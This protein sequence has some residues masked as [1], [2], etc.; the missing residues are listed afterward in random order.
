MQDNKKEKTFQIR[1]STVDFL[2]FT[3]QNSEDGIEVRVQ[4]ESLWLTQEG[5]SQLF[6]KGRTTITEHLKNIF[7]EGE[8]E[9]SSVCRKFRHTGSD[10]KNYNTKF[11]SLDAIISVGYRVNSVRA[12]QFRQWATKVLRTYTIQGYVLDKKRLENGQ[13]FDEE[14]FEHL[15]DEIRE[16]RASE[17]KFYQKITDIYATAVDY[18]KDAY[19][20]KDFFAT[21]QN[22][23]SDFRYIPILSHCKP[24][25]Q[26]ILI[27]PGITLPINRNIILRSNRA[28]A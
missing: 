19:I 20:T 21:V 12:T 24:G 8:L 13:I 14:Y 25:T 26:D 6:D 18:S 5:I 16:I 4:D 10:G 11:Y 7:E 28:A 22:K 3:K 27:I 9:E 15:L 1:N 23:Y 17:R 2:V